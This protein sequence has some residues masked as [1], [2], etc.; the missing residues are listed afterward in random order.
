MKEEKPAKSRVERLQEWKKQREVAKAKQ[1]K[2]EKKNPPFRPCGNKAT[3]PA[4]KVSTHLSPAMKPLPTT[5]KCENS[6]ISCAKV[7]TDAK[8]SSAIK[9]TVK[10]KVNMPPRSSARLAAKHQTVASVVRDTVPSSSRAMS[11]SQTSTQ[12]G[13][14]KKQG[15]GIAT[16]PPAGTKGRNAVPVSKSI[17]A[18]AV[19]PVTK[20]IPAKTQKI[21]NDGK[22]STRSATS[23]S[24]TST[25]SSGV[26]KKSTSKNGKSKNSP[27]NKTTNAGETIIEMV[28]NV[29]EGSEDPAEPPTPTKR[30]YMPVHPSPLLKRQVAPVRRETMFMQ[31]LVNDPAWIP[32]AF[33]DDGTDVSALIPD[34]DEAFETESFSP[35]RFTAA[36]LVQ[37]GSAFSYSPE[38]QQ[39]QFVFKPGPASKLNY[40]DY[41]TTSS[42]TEIDSSDTGM[43]QETDDPPAKKRHHNSKRRSRKLEEILPMIVDNVNSDSENGSNTTNAE[44]TEEDPTSGMLMCTSVCRNWSDF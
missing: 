13:K 9:K 4:V 19:A 20:K 27:K 39:C 43:N 8:M 29:D 14:N 10:N 11:K 22:R 36:Q 21:V 2:Q 33:R 42:A 7:P 6:S 12:V 23:G 30:S 44:S 1:R 28:E 24:T 17:T 18:K 5:K 32:G 35:F 41:G 40:D 26:A 38:P 3:R 37:S 16:K 34:F 31:P 15:V 25:K